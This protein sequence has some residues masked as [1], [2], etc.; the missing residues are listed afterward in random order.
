MQVGVEDVRE[1]FELGAASLLILTLPLQNNL[2]Q[3]CPTSITY[4]G[5]LQTMSE[6]SAAF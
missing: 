5:Q 1:Q 3:Y 6:K 4:I 2:D